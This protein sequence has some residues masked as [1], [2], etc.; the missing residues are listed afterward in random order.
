MKAIGKIGRKFEGFVPLT[1]RWLSSSL[2]DG[3]KYERLPN[4]KTSTN[5]L[6]SRCSKELS[7]TLQIV[8]IDIKLANEDVTMI[9]LH[10]RISQP[11]KFLL[12]EMVTKT[13]L[14]QQVHKFNHRV[15]R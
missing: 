9:A 7:F 2:E 13:V 4:S 10:P 15:I 3:R 8:R 6:V 11:L 14:K 5:K 1:R 12:T